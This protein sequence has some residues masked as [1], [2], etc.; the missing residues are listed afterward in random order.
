MIDVEFN[1]RKYQI[2]DANEPDGSG[3]VEIFIRVYDV[4]NKVIFPR[5]LSEDFVRHF[6]NCSKSK[7]SATTVGKQLKDIK[8]MIS[9]DL[10]ESKQDESIVCYGVIQTAANY[11]K[12][13]SS[14]LIQADNDPKSINQSDHSRILMVKKGDMII[15]VTSTTVPDPLAAC[16]VSLG[17][18]T[19]DG[20]INGGL[21]MA[22]VQYNALPE[23]IPYQREFDLQKF[24]PKDSDSCFM[25]KLDSRTGT[26]KAKEGYL[27]RLSDKLIGEIR[28]IIDNKP[29]N[30]GFWNNIYG[31]SGMITITN[32][33]DVL[34]NYINKKHKNQVVLTGAP[35]T[36]KTFSAIEFAK[37]FKYE[38]EFV[39]FHPS[40]D[41]SD[42]VEGLRPVLLTRGSPPT[43]VRLDGTFKAF[44]RHVV[45]ENIKELDP[46]ISDF[47]TTFEN[48]YKGFVE[49]YEECE[50]NKKDNKIFIFIIDEINRA[51][52]SKVFGEL[53]FAL[54][55]GYRGPSK[56]VNTQYKNL[57]IYKIN[58]TT[59]CAEEMKF[60]CFENG[61]FIPRNVYI[62]G[63][64][65]DID[66]SVESFDFALRRRFKWLDIKANNVLHE[67]FAEMF[68]GKGYTQLKQLE[69]N[70]KEMN[71][72]LSDDDKGGKAFM[73]NEAYHI[74]HAYF[75]DFKDNISSLQEIFDTDISSII[76]EYTRGRDA[77]KVQGLINECWNKLS[78]NIK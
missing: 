70:I 3:K 56:V 34:D 7:S 46:T 60:D 49:K 74:G 21:I 61:F 33:I 45:E 23:P 67:A 43:F 41:Y 68:A 75:K 8:S 44:C 78:D 51:E 38:Y 63:T 13:S 64:M 26:V 59:K 58:K 77:N 69:D 9:K 53:M 1:G 5:K 36:G 6:L 35:G 47:E 73:L 27:F 28:R 40:Y 20:C 31:G 65:N 30:K 16:V 48:D 17:I 22:P 15:S 24:S 42:F 37:K 72:F 10:S 2:F 76:K 50:K 11:K 62:I 29:K 12:H 39:Q 32:I 71:K 25:S 66:R 54:E 57:P 18:A 19:G 4:L 14:G 55:E 52:L